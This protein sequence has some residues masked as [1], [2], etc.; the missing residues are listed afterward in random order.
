MAYTKLKI[1]ADEA[2]LF[3]AI[4]SFCV[5]IYN[6]WMAPRVKTRRQRAVTTKEVRDMLMATREKKQYTIANGYV[7]N[8]A[9]TI[10]TLT[11]GILESD[12]VNGRTGTT[13]RPFEWQINMTLISGVGSTN[14]A[15]RLIIF[16]D[17]MNNG[18][19]P[20]ITDVLDAGLFNSTY[21]ILAAQQGR[22]KILWD[23]TVGVVGG[24]NSAVTHRHLRRKLKGDIFY[25][26]TGN[27]AASN[28][29]NAMFM[30][31]LTDSV[32]VSTAG[33]N[34]FFSLHYTDA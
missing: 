21:A 23:E 15:H 29:K 30:I 6:N 9:G 25:N 18:T 10:T 12:T 16:K 19:I 20:A 7:N 24:S 31:T 2:G 27:V 28:G 34:Y 3:E 5:F 1:Q 33:I 13:I 26:S 8:V 22:Y 32:T 4:N 11:Q 17:T 14:S